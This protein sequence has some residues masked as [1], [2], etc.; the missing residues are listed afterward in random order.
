MYYYLCHRGPIWNPYETCVLA[1][2]MDPY[3]ENRDRLFPAGTE[4]FGGLTV[5]G[6]FR[7]EQVDSAMSRGAVLYSNIAAEL[8]MQE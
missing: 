1:A 2:S 4:G 6:R 5:I 8:G 3:Y 7:A